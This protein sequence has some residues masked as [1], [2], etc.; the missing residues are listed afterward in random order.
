MTSSVFGQTFKND[1]RKYARV[2]NAYKQK[3][4]F[5]KDK[6]KNELKLST[7][8]N[9]ILIVAYK[10][11]ELLEV[12]TKPKDSTKYQLFITYPFC[13]SSGE[14]GPK[15]AHGD[16]QIPEGFYHIDRFNPVSSF[17]LSLGLNYPNRSDRIL[18]NK[19]PGGDIFLHGACCTIGCIPITDDKIME[20]Y[21]LAIEAK[22]SGQAKV[23]VYIFPCK[24]TSKNYEV[25]KK[26]HEN[27][28]ELL[29]FWENI[30]TGY[31]KFVETKRTVP[32]SINSKGKYLFK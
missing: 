16:L 29:Q 10:K 12:W 13:S 3:E 15:R 27:E 26:E 7:L 17:Y 25:L 32:F 23:P 14:L 2:R 9:D 18:G 6:L 28:A 4:Q 31:D 20:L 24:M 21:I 5:L 19:N 1:Q 11:E 8:R 30:K 22:N